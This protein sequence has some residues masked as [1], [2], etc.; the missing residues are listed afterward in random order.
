MIYFFLDCFPTIYKSNIDET[1]FF[2]CIEYNILFYSKTIQYKITIHSVV[3]KL[4][5]CRG[6]DNT[7]IR[8]TDFQK[9][10]LKYIFNINLTIDLTDRNIKNII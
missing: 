10:L 1:V 2:I 8:P 6:L 4:F 5:F 7:S 3:M 9:L